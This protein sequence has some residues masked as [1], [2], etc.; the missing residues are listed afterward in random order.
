[1]YN[2]ICVDGHYEGYVDGVFY[3]SGDTYNEVFEE[4]RTI[5]FR[6]ERLS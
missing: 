1:M 2:I 6:E 4:M 5:M 3:C